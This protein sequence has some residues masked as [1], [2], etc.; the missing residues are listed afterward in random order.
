LTRD[1]PAATPG[2]PPR[3]P[4]R[5]GGTARPIVIGKD[6]PLVPPRFVYWTIIAGGLPT[7]FRAV[8]REDLLPTFHR[9][10]E[11]HPDAELKWFARGKLWESKEAADRERDERRAR[12]LER[13]AGP[14]PPGR[15]GGQRPPGGDVSRRPSRPR[16]PG[17]RRGRD[18]RPGGEHVDPRQKYKDAKKARNLDHRKEKFARKQGDQRPRDQPPRDKEAAPRPRSQDGPPR[19]ARTDWKG[20]PQGDRPKTDRPWS[21]KPR[22]DK[23]RSDRPPFPRPTG[24]APGS[25]RPKP[26][27]TSRPGGSSSSRPGGWTSRPR[28]DG[29]P[30]RDR[31]PDERV[32]KDRDTNKG[33]DKRRK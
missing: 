13:A 29:R 23:P 6:I 16:T 30:P 10:R 24:G 17:D 2:P 14:K 15:E 32:G 26:G 25:G 20:R 33:K 11:K 18:W 7:A 3:T 1:S 8:E 5:W 27:P 9:I 19:P 28:P 31:R 22:V 4:A 21:G 12:S